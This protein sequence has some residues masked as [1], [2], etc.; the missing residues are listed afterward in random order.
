MK[1]SN[2]TLLRD[3]QILLSENISKKLLNELNDKVIVTNKDT[4]NSYEVSKDYYNANKAKYDIAKPG[5]KPTNSSPQKPKFKAVKQKPSNDDIVNMSSIGKSD[6]PTKAKKS[7]PSEPG[8]Q[9]DAY[10]KNKYET[11]RARNKLIGLSKYKDTPQGTKFYASSSHGD[12]YAYTVK[13]KQQANYLKKQTLAN[14]NKWSDQNKK[15]PNRVP[16]NPYE[17]HEEP[18]SHGQAVRAVKNVM[19]QYGGGGGQQGFD[20][21]WMQ[22]QD[23]V[24]ALMKKIMNKSFDRKQYKGITYHDIGNLVSPYGDYTHAENGKKLPPEY[25][26][27]QLKL[28]E[29]AD[30]AEQYAMNNKPKEDEITDQDRINDAEYKKYM[31][32]IWDKYDK[33]YDEIQK[34]PGGYTQEK[35]DAL[36]KLAAQRKKADEEASE[37]FWKSLRNK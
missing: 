15:N 13:D 5:T 23:E 22:H 19:K 3:I 28:S 17:S 9:Q 10:M 6:A 32:P 29:I 21:V 7:M 36:Q 11:S 12:T 8:P 33:M 24:G 37:K 14:R 34:M 26:Q 35:Y 1:K 18:K 31:R 20:Q 2:I 25:E 4:G 30:E 27:L 16:D